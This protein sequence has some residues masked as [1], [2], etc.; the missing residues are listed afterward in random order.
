M[1]SATLTDLLLQAKETVHNILNNE[2]PPEQQLIATA[3]CGIIALYLLSNFIF[4]ILVCTFLVGAIVAFYFVPTIA[5]VSVLALASIYVLYVKWVFH[6]WEKAFAGHRL[7]RRNEA[8]PSNKQ[9]PDVKQAKANKAH[10]KDNS[11]LHENFDN[12]ELLH[13][14]DEM[15]TSR[16]ENKA[17]RERAKRFGTLTAAKA[18]LLQDQMAEG[19]LVDDKA[20]EL[21]MD[22][23]FVKVSIML[24][25]L[26]LSCPYS[27]SHI[28]FSSA[29][30]I[31]KFT[32]F[33]WAY[34][35]IGPFS[36]LLWLRGTTVLR[37]RKFLYGLGLI[38]INCDYEEVRDATFQN[39][40]MSDIKRLVLIFDSLFRKHISSLQPLLYWSKPRQSTTM[41]GHTRRQ[42]NW[43]ILRG[44][45]LLIF[46]MWIITAICKLPTC[47][48]WILIWIPIGLSRPS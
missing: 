22:H 38:R 8:S 12:C 21:D 23:V 42:A 26:M 9:M 5:L 7:S 44:S 48:P 1:D 28:M 13:T 30:N 3:V 17:F 10:I 15:K 29:T 4:P 6:E 24:S 40:I 27:S 43:G 33:L 16:K 36:Y 39:A 46:H 31:L 34:T 19:S 2:T 41:V 37:V 20:K 25:L 14:L 11:R 35:F 47:L 45:S 32:D 18:Q